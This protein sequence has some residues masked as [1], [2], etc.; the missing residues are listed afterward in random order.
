[1]VD[2]TFCTTYPNLTYPI[3]SIHGS[4]GPHAAKYSTW[5]TS[6]LQQTSEIV[7]CS[8]VSYLTSHNITNVKIVLNFN[9]TRI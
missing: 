2:A 7:I 8:Y 6:K 1:M 4:L 9:W 5:F 3:L